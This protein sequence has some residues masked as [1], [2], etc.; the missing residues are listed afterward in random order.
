MKLVVVTGATRGLGLEVARVLL[1]RGYNVVAV[2]RR[3]SPAFEE[4]CREYGPR[5]N[6]RC[7]DLGE[8][9]GIK[10][11]VSETTRCH[12]PIYGLVNNAAI[13]ADGLLATMH[14]SDIGSA[15]RINLEAPLV[16]AKY[17]MRSMLLGKEGRI[18]N[19]SSIVA[20]TG[21]KGLVAYAAAK[22]GLLGMTRS[23][24][25]EVGKA[26]IT[27]N[28]VCPGFLE[29]EMTAGLQG[30]KLESV[31]RRTALGRLPKLAEVAHGIAY[32]LSE[33]AAGVTGTT[34]TIDAGSAA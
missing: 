25:R 20:G 30:Q 33:E 3:P 26:G 15:L 7:F 8:I 21:Y 14:D 22:A 1:N 28:A 19:V 29:T 32:L 18:V 11:L 9:A 16:L 23:L 27:V 17:A 34:L 2:G 24:A 13:G 31:V 10:H 12:G 4:L 5:L 6:M